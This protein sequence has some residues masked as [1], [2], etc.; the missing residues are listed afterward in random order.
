[1]T[2]CFLW[3]HRWSIWRTYEESSHYIP[4]SC[5]L[6]ILSLAHDITEV[7]ETRRC[8]RCGRTQ[9]RKIKDG[10]LSPMPTVS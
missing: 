3:I 2:H 10:P 5:G 4:H 8:Q 7:R 9:D 6:P 1:M